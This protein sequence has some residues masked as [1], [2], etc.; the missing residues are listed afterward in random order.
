MEYYR[1]TLCCTYGELMA[2]GVSDSAY[3]HMVRR[4]DLRVMRRGCRGREALVAYAGMPERVR[5]M[6]EEMVGDPYAAARRCLLAEYLTDRAE[7]ADYLDN[8]R[9]HSGRL[10][11]DVK[12]RE[13]YANAMVLEA[14][15]RM[16]QAARGIRVAQGGRLSVKLDAD[17]NPTADMAALLREVHYCETATQSYQLKLKP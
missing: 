8:F 14:I 16:M 10:L 5:R 4:G 2:A 13:Y 11:P 17:A 7:V 15:D 6:V 9:T 12:R 1:N 3:D